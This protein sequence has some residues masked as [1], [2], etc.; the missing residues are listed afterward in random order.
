MGPGA[1]ATTRGAPRSG[2]GAP[3]G[4]ARA[5]KLGAMH[6]DDLRVFLAVAQAGSLRRAGRAL[7]LG[8]P[9]VV[10]HLRQL[11][12][13][14]GARLFERR[15]D[16]HRLTRAGEDLLPMAQ[17][18]AEAATTIDRRRATF[19]EDAAGLVRVAAGEWS[20]RFLASRLAGLAA[21]HPEL[22][23]ELVE[24]HAD[25]DLDRRE[26]DLLVSHG[27]RAR[28]HLVRVGLGTMAI[29]IYGARALVEAQPAA[30]TEARWRACPWVAYD[31]PHEY[32]RSMAWLAERLGNNRPRIRASRISLQLEE[33][34]SGAGL[35]ILP[36][37]AGDAD[38]SLV[39]LTAPITDLAA[40]IWLFV[41]PD[42]RAVPRV[43]L[44]IEWIRAAFKEGRPV[45]GSNRK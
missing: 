42:L 39:R 9:T 33:I 6:W 11:E 1:E 22:T 28:G 37:Y 32:F 29:A 31:T 43:R 15:P 10:R 35:G 8:Q 17:S 12:H 13:A 26:A 40:D 19:S 38:P 20:A 5:A 24:T 44:V 3:A 30:R 18:M 25:P 27:V 36:C 21:G 14:L 23:V 4:G 34:R 7:R 2:C 16:G 45:L 41:H